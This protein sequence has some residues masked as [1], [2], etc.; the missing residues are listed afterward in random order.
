MGQGYAL[1][2]Y[3]PT[4]H[5]RREQFVQ[6]TMTPAFDADSPAVAEIIECA[7]SDKAMFPFKADVSIGSASW[8]WPEGLVSK[9][10]LP[11]Y[12]KFDPSRQLFSRGAH[13]PL[14]IFVG[15]SKETRRSK[16]ALARRAA[17]ANR[18]GWTWERRQSTRTQD[19]KGKGPQTHG[20]GEP[21]DDQRKGDQRKGGKGGR[22]HDFLKGKGKGKKG[23]RFYDFLKGSWWGQP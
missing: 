18:R 8:A 17:N 6:W 12:E 4:E 9:Q 7:R 5:K 3:R 20:H 10:K 21:H 11:V 1:T 22:F 13:M 19:D 23:G 15:A 14:M 2:T 16:E